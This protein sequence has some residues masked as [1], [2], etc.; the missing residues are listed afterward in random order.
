MIKFLDA[1]LIS[2]GTSYRLEIE[3]EVEEQTGK[4]KSAQKTGNIVKRWIPIS[5]P[6]TIEN[7]ILIYLRRKGIEFADSEEYNTLAETVE[8]LNNI[9]NEIK[10]QLKGI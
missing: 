10:E 7:A 2:D 6:S 1:R 5:Y 8:Y 3:K 9:K 4:G